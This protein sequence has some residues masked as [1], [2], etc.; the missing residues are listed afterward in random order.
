MYVAGGGGSKKNNLGNDPYFLYAGLFSPRTNLAL[1]I[2]KLS[3]PIH[4]V[5]VFYSNTLWKK[6][7]LS[8]PFDDGAVGGK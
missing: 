7:S 5:C 4:D 2:F 6:Y 8:S 3:H 1:T